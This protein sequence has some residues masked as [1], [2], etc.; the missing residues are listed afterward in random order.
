MTI[1]FHYPIADLNAGIGR[2]TAWRDC[3]YYREIIA[4]YR[5]AN[6]TMAIRSKTSD[7]AY[8]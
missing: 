3:R 8:Q 4:A 2:R 1:H 7:T 6:P 5:D